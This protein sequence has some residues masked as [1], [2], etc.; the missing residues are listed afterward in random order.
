V[1][2]DGHEEL[3]NDDSAGNTGGLLFFPQIHNQ[4]NENMLLSDILLH[5][6]RWI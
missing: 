1:I 4:H 5:P 2:D 6:H 3:M